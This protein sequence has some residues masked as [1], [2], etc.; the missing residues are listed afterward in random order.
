M[1]TPNLRLRAAV[2]S[3]AP[4]LRRWESAPHLAELLG[5]DDWEWEISLAAPHPG[6]RPFVAE[7]D[8][9][10]VEFLEILG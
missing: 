10:P 3:D 9:H 6:H 1:P 8:G 4:M 7:V 5:D 2:P